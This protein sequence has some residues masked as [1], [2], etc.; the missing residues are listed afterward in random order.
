MLY[1]PYCRLDIFLKSFKQKELL[2]FEAFLIYIYEIIS[3]QQH[4]SKNFIEFHFAF[5]EIKKGEN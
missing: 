1:P 2:F 4:I 5:I 3:Y